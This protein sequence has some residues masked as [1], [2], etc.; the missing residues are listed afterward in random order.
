MSDQR[1]QP[2]PS[3]SCCASFLADVF[4]WFQSAFQDIVFSDA[5]GASG[6]EEDADS[7]QDSP[8]SPA[9]PRKATWIRIDGR[10][11]SQ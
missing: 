5:E 4:E 9:G 6:D 2:S 7:K 8:R 10:L 11:K 3:S 1:R